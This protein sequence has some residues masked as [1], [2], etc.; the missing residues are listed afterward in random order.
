MEGSILSENSKGTRGRKRGGRLSRGDALA[1]VT[2]LDRQLLTAVSAQ[3][4]LTQ[5]QLERLFADVPGRTLRYRTGRLTRLGVLGRSRPYRDRG[6][7]PFHYWPTRAADAFARAEP[8]PRGGE[9]PEPNP[10]FLAHAAG[11]S[12][13]YV[14]LAVEAP[15]VGLRLRGF[16]REGDAR[17]PFRADGRERALAPDALIDLEDEQGRQ[18]LGFMELDLG[19]M[20]HA[21]LKTKAAGYAAY[22]AEA[23]WAERHPFCPCLLFLTTTEA[24]AIS[25]LKALQALLEKSAGGGY[26]DRRGAVSWFAAGAC[27]MARAPERALTEA[28]WDDLR[29]AGGGRTLVDCLKSARAPYD[30]ARAEEQA[31]QRAA[32][33][34]RERLRSDPEARRSF[35]QE[36][37]LYA[38]GEHLEQFG[39]PGAAALELLLHSTEPMDDVERNAFAAFARQLADDPLEAE[40]APTPAP[41]TRADTDAVNRLVDAYRAR[42]RARVTELARRYGEG[43]KLRRLRDR[44]GAGELLDLYAWDALEENAR[45]D[46][47]ARTEQERLRLS[48][49]ESREREARRRKHEPG[50]A[51][52]LAHGRAAALALV[53]RDR[54]RICPR[55]DEIVYPPERKRDGYVIQQGYQEPVRCHFCGGHELDQW[56][57]A[58]LPQLE[59]GGDYRPFELDLRSSGPAGLM[60]DPDDEEGGQW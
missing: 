33:A 5:T 43:P 10:Q 16:R 12:E 18:L 14:L 13:L 47:Q 42:Q 48:Y 50:L 40:F 39:E 23:A 41:P 3:R 49:L 46:Q 52:R 37:R 31:E 2:E 27:A 38:R 55:C 4:V 54:L 53:D 19:T 28:C 1:T 45:Q 24:R 26:Y 56:D 30:A 59:Y 36:K 7:A 57:E 60:D 8:V 20:S 34:E 11:L 29:L 51:A 58:R 17:E 32:E 15:T 25:F 44:L 6:S 21:R 22:A 35:L 9:R